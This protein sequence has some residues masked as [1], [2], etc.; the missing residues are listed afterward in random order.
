M[1]IRDRRGSEPFVEQSY[2]LE[3]PNYSYD[4]L[5]KLSALRA[6]RAFTDAI[7][8]VGAEEIPCHR[9][10]LAVS[11]PYFNAMF[12]SDLR[13]SKEIKISFNEI[14]AVTMRRVIDYAYT[15]ILEINI[16][17]AQDML[18]AATLFQYEP[19]ADACCEFLSKQIHAS[20]CLGIEHFAHLH[21]C[22]NLELEAHQYALENFSS[23]VEYDEFLEVPKDRLLTYLSSDLIDVRNEEIVYNATLKWIKFDLESRRLFIGDVLEQVR[24]PTINLDYIETVIEK[25]PLIQSFEKCK[26]LIQEAKKYHETIVD[27]HGKRR[28]S[29]QTAQTQPRPST[30]AKEVMVLVGG[31]NNYIVQSVEMY[32]PTKDKWSPLPDLPQLVSWFSVAALGNDVYVS[33]GIVDGHI[34]NSVWKFESGK[35]L[36]Y[37]VNPMLTPRAR[38]ASTSLDSKMYV[39]GGIKFDGKIVAVESIESYDMDSQQWTVV[40]HSPLPRKQSHIAPYNKTLVEIGGTQGDA[41]VQTIE[42]YLISDAALRSSGEQFVLPECIQFSQIVVLNGVLYIMWEDSKKFIALNPEKRTFRRL[43][44]M[45]YAH[46]HSGATVLHEKIYITGGLVDSK[47]SRITECFDPATNTW[48]IVRSMH[49]ARACHGCVLIQM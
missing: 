7:L 18:A 42:S 38:H 5:S 28:R 11:S 4:I 33:G 15:G 20:N 16:E 12:S 30:F 3:D 8:C 48:T 1:D 9:N 27:Q 26:L 31:I 37:K 47:P 10:V 35:R 2:H 36:W 23:V 13:E 49:Q 6:E 22:Q 19:I 45:H 43:P 14:T 40:G 39:V 41:K 24:L 34:V 21:S 29:M 17:N 44:D 25:D 32:E 46:I